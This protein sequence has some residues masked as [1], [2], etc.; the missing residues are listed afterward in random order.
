[1]TVARNRNRDDHITRRPP[2][3]RILNTS[4]VLNANSCLLGSDAHRLSGASIL[5]R[6]IYDFSLPR[7]DN[8][9]H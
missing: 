3:I 9:G 4:E 8:T 1:M 2:N 5:V 6:A 7:L